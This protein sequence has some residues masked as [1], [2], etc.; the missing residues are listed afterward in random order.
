MK[1]I[2]INKRKKTLANAISK[3]DNEQFLF[4]IEQLVN[5]LNAM[6][7]S[8]SL[9]LFFKPAKE[10]LDIDEM[11]SEQKFSGI[12]RAKFDELVEKINI[13]EPLPELLKQIK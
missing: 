2:E 1:T 6:K 9:N 8:D 12:D 4:R 13:S 10:D 11:I 3:F 7:D 5:S